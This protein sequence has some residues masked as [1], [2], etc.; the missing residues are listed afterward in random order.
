[1]LT[2]TV[3]RCEGT[4]L[5]FYSET[6]T[7]DTMLCVTLPSTGDCDFTHCRTFRFVPAI[8]INDSAS[9]CEG[10]TYMWY[11]QPYT[12][13]GTFTHLIETGSAVCDTLA[14]PDLEAHPSY[15][16]NLIV[17]LPPGSSYTVGD[18]VLTQAGTYSILLATA[19]GCDSLIRVRVEITTD[20]DEPKEGRCVVPNLI[21]KGKAPWQVLCPDGARL[22]GWE[23]YDIY[24]RRVAASNQP[25]T[26]FMLLDVQAQAALAAGVYCY[27]IGVDDNGTARQSTGKVV[28]VE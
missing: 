8:E 9:I 24:G 19:Q 21:H 20:T 22:L 18:S 3:S 28:L 10:E 5:S 17:N 4:T 7:T 1:M 12:Q 26:S 6:V 2:D 23:L 15:E 27:R 16:R 14:I 25:S 11:G 13:T